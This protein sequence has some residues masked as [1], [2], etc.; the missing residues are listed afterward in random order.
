[1]PTLIAFILVP[2]LAALATAIAAAPLGNL[3]IWRRLVYFGET[4]AHS[5]LLGIAASLLLG[6][7]PYLGI[8]GITLAIV[9]TLH[10]LRRHTQSD[11]NTIL[12]SLSHLALA[13][14]YII[15]SRLEHI[16]TDLTAY[17]FGDILATRSHDLILILILSIA[18]LL[19]VRKLWQPLILMTLS[20]DIASAENKHSARHDFCFLLLL[21]LFIGFMAQFFGLLLV[22]ALLIIPANAS[23]RLAQ[24]PEQSVLLAALISALSATLGTALAWWQDWPPSP[25]I[26]LFTGLFY[27]AS[28]P[29]ASRQLLKAK[30]F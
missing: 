11:G 29:A 28:L 2:W 5:A 16:R 27:L 24:T 10:H 3:L 23:S 8:W 18:T 25:S 13:A 12:G 21:G 15:I 7:P 22:I 20:P 30:G 14:G 19:T 1:M 9:L 6:I 4:I 17:F 26:V